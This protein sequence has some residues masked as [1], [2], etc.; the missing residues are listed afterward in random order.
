MS[1]VL[2]S[3]AGDILYSFQDAFFSFSNTTHDIHGNN[4]ITL[5]SNGCL[6]GGLRDC[7]VACQE[8]NR[9]FENTATL[10]NC[11]HYPLIVHAISEEL[12]ADGS[13][14][15]A[16]HYRIS[17]ADA[18]STT[19]TT[20]ALQQCLTD[21]ALSTPESSKYSSTACSGLTQSLCYNNTNICQ[22]VYAPVIE[23]IA[24]VGVSV[25]RPD[26]GAAIDTVFRSIP[27]TGCRMA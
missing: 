24:G 21:Y 3:L 25:V 2:Q 15:I 9:I 19:S 7:G 10:H 26:N 13:E 5:F 6:I 4:V 27:L 22:S 12:L 11:L 14:M 18:A 20:N 1:L 8:T 16:Q 23:D 17:G